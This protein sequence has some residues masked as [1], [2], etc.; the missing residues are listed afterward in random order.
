M[1]V[2]INYLNNFLVK[3]KTGAG[4]GFDFEKTKS[5]FKRIIGSSITELLSKFYLAKLAAE[6][7]LEP[8]R[9]F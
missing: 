1:Q 4:I 5:G 9:G 7:M 2:C 8:N 3:S 6:P